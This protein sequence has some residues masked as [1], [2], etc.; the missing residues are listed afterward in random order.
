MVAAVEK[1]ALR[2]GDDKGAEHEKDFRSTVAPVHKVA[3]EDV[4]VGGRRQAV[5]FQNREQVLC[6]FVCARVCVCVCAR[7]CAC[8]CACVRV[9]VCV[10]VCVCVV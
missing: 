5:H 7:V 1:D 8:V 3:I 2:A 10:C 4:G 6:V 9:C